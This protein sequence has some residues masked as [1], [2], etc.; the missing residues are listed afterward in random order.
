MLSKRLNDIVLI[1]I[2]VIVIG[3]IF[4]GR[5]FVLGNIDDQIEATEQ[6]ILDVENAISVDQGLVDEY[7]FENIPSESHL[8]AQIPR[9]F[10]SDVLLYKVEAHLHLSGIEFGEGRGISIGYNENVTF[11]ENSR[12]RQ[13]SQDY[14]TNVVIIDFL[15]YDLDEIEDVIVQLYEANQLFLLEYIRFEEVNSEDHAF[16]LA[17]RLRF[18]TFYFEE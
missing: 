13:L 18:A 6:E 1:G 4:A 8:T 2:F 16:N 17:V 9:D 14:F 5:V 15:A 3:L 11:S 10:N 7:R 12:Y